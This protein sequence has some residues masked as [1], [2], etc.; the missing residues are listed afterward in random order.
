VWLGI[1]LELRSYGMEKETIAVLKGEL[2]LSP[3][4]VKLLK[5]I[6]E[7]RSELEK[8]MEESLGI[9]KAGI[10]DMLDTILEKQRGEQKQEFSVL[11]TYLYFAIGRETPG[12]L[13]VS[14]EGHHQFHPTD[15][16]PTDLPSLSE[17]LFAT[18]Y[19][20]LSLDGI[21]RFY[22]A[23]PLVSRPVKNLF[24]THREQQLIDETRQEGIKSLTIRFKG[25]RMEQLESTKQKKVLL[26]ARLSEVLLK[27]GYENLTISTEK[28]QIVYAEQTIKKRFNNEDN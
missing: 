20:T 4:Y 19:V 23:L 26:E 12:L 2:L 21:M 3:D 28:G 14:K 22:A 9:S 11:A 17:G 6:E 7:Q 27:G 8:T 1:V 10:R 15:L 5:T 13:L 18:S 25:G 16:S 24:L